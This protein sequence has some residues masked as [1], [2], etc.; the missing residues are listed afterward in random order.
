MKIKSK[1]LEIQRFN[2]ESSEKD[3]R[4]GAVSVA[5]YSRVAELLAVAESDF[6]TTKVEFNTAY[7]ILQEI[8]GINLNLNNSIKK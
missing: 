2:M 7:L 6:Q 1:Y 8:V 4:S 5:D 3:F